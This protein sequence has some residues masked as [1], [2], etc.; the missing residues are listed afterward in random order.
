MPVCRWAFDEA[1]GEGRVSA[2]P[3]AYRLKEVNGSIA[4]VAGRAK[5]ERAV[6]IEAGKY[7]TIPD[8]EF[9]AIDF[10]GPEVELSVIAWVL[11][12]AASRWL[13]VAGIWNE[14]EK[15]RQYCLILN[16]STCSDARTMTRQPTK[17]EAHGHVSDVGGPTEGQKYC[18]TYSSSGTEIPLNELTMVVMAFD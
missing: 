12:K 13:A 1:A 10:H 7:F 6:R 4:V 15:Q 5:E 17:D 18:I 3:N 14:M 16:S 8:R 2:D 9:E 11:R